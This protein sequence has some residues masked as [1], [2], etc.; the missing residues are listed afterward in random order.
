MSSTSDMAGKMRTILLHKLN[1]PA[2]KVRLN[3][4]EN[5]GKILIFVIVI[6][7]VY[8]V[9]TLWPS[10]QL[11]APQMDLSYDNDFLKHRSMGLSTWLMFKISLVCT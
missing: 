6:C 4:K 1:K 2:S 9:F 3:I 8:S 5:Q 10:R 7:K 11:C